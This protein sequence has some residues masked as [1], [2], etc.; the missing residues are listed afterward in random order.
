MSRSQPRRPF[1]R[2][3]F[4]I[5]V[6][7][8]LNLYTRGASLCPPSSVL[9]RQSSVL[10]HLSSVYGPLS[11]LARRSHEAKAAVLRPLYF[12]DFSTRVSDKKSHVDQVKGRADDYTLL[13]STRFNSRFR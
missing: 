7:E 4:D 10:G 9:R 2:S 13:W 12:L 8:E 11:S 3:Y 5:T 1:D 6:R